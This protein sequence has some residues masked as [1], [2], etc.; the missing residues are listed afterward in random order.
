MQSKHGEAALSKGSLEGKDAVSSHVSQGSVQ[1]AQTTLA[2]L[3]LKEFD[4]GN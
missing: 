4:G 3:K 2:I 1:K